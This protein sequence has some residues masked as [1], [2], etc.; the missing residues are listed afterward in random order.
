[1]NDLYEDMGE[2][3]G[4]LE[5]YKAELETMILN[6]KNEKANRYLRGAICGIQRALSEMSDALF[7]ITTETLNLDEFDDDYEEQSTSIQVRVKFIGS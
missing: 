4:G 1:M 7:E 6:G 5:A 3:M 2:V